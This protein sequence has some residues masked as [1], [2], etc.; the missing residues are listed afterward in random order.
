M[1]TKQH[2]THLETT[3]RLRLAQTQ[4]ELEYLLRHALVQDARMSRCY[5]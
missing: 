5:W 3:G 1:T 2:L 4:P